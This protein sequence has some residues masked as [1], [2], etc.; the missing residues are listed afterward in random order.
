MQPG[1]SGPSE[2]V[3]L[4]E[5]LGRLVATMDDSGRAQ[6]DRG[7]ALVLALS[8]QLAAGQ[9]ETLYSLQSAA[10]TVRDRAK[11]I[12][13][14]AGELP[15]EIGSRVAA[16]VDELTEAATAQVTQALDEASTR[17][18]IAL[19]SVQRELT[20]HQEHYLGALQES[21][22]ATSQRLSSQQEDLLVSLREAFESTHAQLRAQQESYLAAL[23]ETA[24]STSTRFEDQ[25]RVYL[26]ALQET[27]ESTSIRFEDQQRDYLATLRET[28][29]STTARLQEQQEAY[30]AVLRE[31]A[32]RTGAQLSRELEQAAKTIVDSAGRAKASQTAVRAAAVAAVETLETVGQT[33][34]E[35]LLELQ[36]QLADFVDQA[37]AGMEQTSAAFAADAQAVTQ[38]MTTVTEG[39]ISRLFEVLDERDERDRQLEERL[40][41]RAEW[42][43]H[44]MAERMSELARDLEA[45]IA[46]LE[47]R[48]LAERASS[49]EILTGL[50]DRL[51]A[52]PRGK[53]RDLRSAA[54]ALAVAPLP[55]SRSVAPARVPVAPTPAPVFEVAGD[56]LGDDADFD[57]EA[58]VDEPPAP[59]RT[60]PP[61]PAKAR[62]KSPAAHAAAQHA[63]AKKAATMK[64][65]TKKA[66]PRKAPVK[67]A[68]RAATATK[69]PT[70]K[71]A[72]PRKRTT[73]KEES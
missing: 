31:S 58:A 57:Q 21:S 62:S 10:S 56:G 23:Q 65:A 59:P 41:A 14:L 50:V 63:P 34:T 39:F 29:E 7:Q 28:S 25:Q 55:Q 71:S 30:L 43:T 17:L 24:E 48:D 42:L 73:T 27:A 32:E 20:R 66:A 64:A 1:P 68:P 22:A 26:T 49:A 16:L 72:A 15:V 9:T 36:E 13:R 38:G 4:V 52:E 12:T 47:E 3:D 11:E 33:T 53:L 2:T 5:R 60:T 69:A 6:M 46:R 61:A 70:K 8:D 19:K 45:Q 35:R 40:N 37:S 44:R 51:L 54:R 18:G 67:T